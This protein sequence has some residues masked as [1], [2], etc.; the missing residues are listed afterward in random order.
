MDASGYTIV[1]A[2]AGTSNIAGE[3]WSDEGISVL[4]IVW[5]I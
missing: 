1:G 5:K 2:A 3:K 4:V